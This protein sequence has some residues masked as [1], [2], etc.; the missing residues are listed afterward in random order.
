MELPERLREGSDDENDVCA[1]RHGGVA[2]NQSIFGLIAAAGSA[3]GLD[4]I[5]SD[6]EEEDSA[7]MPLSQTVPALVPAAAAGGLDGA[8][9]AE[10]SKHRRRSSKA[11]LVK[12]LHKL[13]LKPI[14]E[15]KPSTG[16][17]DMMSSSQILQP[18]RHEPEPEEEEEEDTLPNAPYLN[19][20]LT[21]DK[22][23][24]RELAG[25]SGHED[26]PQSPVKRPLSLAEQVQRL[27]KFSEKQD[28][29]AEYRCQLVQNINVPGYIFVTKRY[30]CFYA[31]LPQMT[32]KVVKTGYI[33]KRGMHDPR[34]HRY[35]CE[36]KGHVLSF[37]EEPAQINYPRSLV[38]M[39]R[40]IGVFGTG[41]EKGKDDAHFTLETDKREYQLRAD[42]AESATN[43]VK[44]LQQELLNTHNDGGL[45]KI[46]L[47]IEN[48]LD[49]EDNYIRGMA[50]AESLRIRVIDNDETYA[51]DEVCSGS[52]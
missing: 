2:L 6:S 35:Y 38:D 39:R 25:G 43:W 32:A 26:R 27:F 7:K 22:Q 1:P 19:R 33:S 8:L 16:G 48:I 11:L 10:P 15:R 37:Y 36:L 17:E 20:I 3:A 31:Y 23:M 12:S 42:S 46:T 34:Y 24:R 50:F 9:Q 5:T 30:I 45:V 4:E 14:R 29:I 44:V 52:G 28:I 40:A 41:H 51:V 18:R 49:I 21:A 47:P 13:R